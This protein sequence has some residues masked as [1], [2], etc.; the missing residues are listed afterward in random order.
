MKVN[1]K[2]SIRFRIYLLAF[3]FF[4]GFGIILARGYQL[5]VLE[6]DKLAS[7]ARAG[8]RETIKLPSKRGT[9][10]DRDGHELAVSVEVGSVYAHPNLI[11][12]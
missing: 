3:F 6:K 5:Q 12:G 4:G 8:Y 9:I 7:I 10:Y 11:K 1:E 2:K